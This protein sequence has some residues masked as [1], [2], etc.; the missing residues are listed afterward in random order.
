MD[1]E[2]N[3]Y[4]IAYDRERLARSKAE[5]LL[6]TKSRELFKSNEELKKSYK[7]LQKQQDAMLQNEK[8]ATLGTL[9]AGM[10]H[11][12]NNPLAFV[13]SNI[14]SL[15]KYHDSYA[16][17]VALIKENMSALS[18]DV[19][20]KLKLFL[21]EED[22][23]FIQEDI[24]ELMQ[25]TMEGLSRVKDIV[26]NLRS[27]ARTQSND[28]CS[29]NIVEGIEN[30]L[31]LLSNELRNEVNL[32]LN[33]QP[34]PEI[35]CN[36]NE[37]NQVFLNLIMNAKH[38]TVVSEKPTI[39]ISSVHEGNNIVIK[40]ADNGCGIKSEIQKDIFVPFFTTKPIGEGT[41]MGLAIAYGII[42]DHGGDITL[43]SIEGRGTSFKIVLPI[44]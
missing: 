5:S 13:K 14:E 33:L 10:A 22:M 26:M 12:I 23:D 6:E 1:D 16:R 20:T 40:I 35:S 31:K 2:S 29:S 24:P 43:S 21:E 34:V 27:F 36:P 7:L 8:L 41:G 44:D 28:R 19:Q 15:P 9:S 38:A 42:K 37:L 17:L 18:P 11:E 25:D 32:K 3:A 39:S 4:K 30:T